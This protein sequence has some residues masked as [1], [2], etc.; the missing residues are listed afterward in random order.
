MP[1]RPA[2]TSRPMYCPLC[3]RPYY[4]SVIPD[5]ST[6]VGHPSDLCGS[7]TPG[8]HPFSFAR[9][10]DL[11]LGPRNRLR[12]NFLL[13]IAIKKQPSTALGLFGRTGFCKAIFLY[14]VTTIVLFNSLEI[15]TIRTS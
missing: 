4:K 3:A 10:L 5:L 1:P 13:V 11:L 6:Q 9:A 14:R 12:T 8:P 7:C 15:A 2:G